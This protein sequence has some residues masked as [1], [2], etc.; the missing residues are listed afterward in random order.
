MPALIADGI[1]SHIRLLPSS[2]GPRLRHLLAPTCLRLRIHGIW[3]VQPYHLVPSQ[4]LCLLRLS[5]SQRDLRLGPSPGFLST[6]HQILQ[7]RR[8]SLWVHRHRHHR[9]SV[10]RI[11][12]GA[13]RSLRAY[14]RDRPDDGVEMV[15]SRLCGH[16]VRPYMQC[17]SQILR[18]SLIA[19]SA[20]VFL[21][22]RMPLQEVDQRLRR[23]DL[24][25][26]GM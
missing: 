2:L 13:R 15:L 24:A 9:L 20:A 22:P 21:I 26:G 8:S 11:R 16:H 4:P 1:P 23:M 12:P 3:D 17:S 6:H 10:Q 5:S 18:R 19:S 25:G 14:P 7:S